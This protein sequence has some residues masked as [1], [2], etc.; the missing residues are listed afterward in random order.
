MNKELI[1]KLGNICSD[2]LRNLAR[3]PFL[4]IVFLFLIVLVSGALIFY[5]YDILVKLSEPKAGSETVQFQ[6]EIYQ[7]ILRE[8]K[9]REERFETADSTK[10]INPFQEKR[11][12]PVPIVPIVSEE[13]KTTSADPKLLGASNLLEFYALRGEKMP[14]LNDRAKMW[15]GFGLGSTGS[16]LGSNSQNQLLLAELK[17]RL[18]E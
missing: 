16:Y 7:Q 11:E 18:T 5:R 14:L 3:N 2:F 12:R 4:A 15:Q 6:K 8:W 17:K 10:Y 9:E 13:P 1:Q